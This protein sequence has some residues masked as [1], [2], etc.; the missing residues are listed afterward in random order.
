MPET[1][2]GNRDLWREHESIEAFIA[3]RL[4]HRPTPQTVVEAVWHCVRD[5]GLAALREP[6]NL[7]RLATLDRTARAQ[8]NERIAKVPVKVGEG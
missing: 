4:R 1:F 6:A 3:R 7:Q 2:G 5:R 8:L